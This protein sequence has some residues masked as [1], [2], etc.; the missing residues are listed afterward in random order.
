VMSEKSKDNSKELALV[1]L[2]VLMLVKLL[3]VALV[4]RLEI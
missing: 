3:E 4:V 2:L 1:Y